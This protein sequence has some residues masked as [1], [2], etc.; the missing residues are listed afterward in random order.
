MCQGFAFIR[1][2]LYIRISCL[3]RRSSYGTG[4]ISIPSITIYKQK[5]LQKSI[6]TLEAFTLCLRVLSQRDPCGSGKYLCDFELSLLNNTITKTSFLPNP[7]PKHLNILNV[8]LRSIFNQCNFFLLYISNNFPR[9]TRNQHTFGNN[10]V[11][12]NNRSRSNYRI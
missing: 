2:F 12:L 11:L 7:F 1:S 10:K 5:R 9:H 6:T 8:M 3:L 4:L